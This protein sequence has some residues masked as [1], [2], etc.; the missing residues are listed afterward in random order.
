MSLSKSIPQQLGP[1]Y[2]PSLAMSKPALACQRRRPGLGL[3]HIPT[4]IC[5]FAGHE[6][7]SSGLSTQAARAG[8]ETYTNLNMRLRWPWE[9]QLWPVN[10]GGQGWDRN[11]YQF[12]YAPSLAMRKPVLACQRRRPGLGPKHIPTWIYAFAGH[13]RNLALACQRRR[14]GGPKYIPIW[15]CAFAGHVRK[16]WWSKATFNN[17][18]THNLS[19]A[20]PRTILD[21]S[22]TPLKSPK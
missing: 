18:R 22:L 5:A 9:N 13:V 14:P 6:K 15:I 7:T 11:I 10:A 1:E 12:E 17:L 8:T 4:W 2:A 19:F 3:K 21:Y 16:L 20:M